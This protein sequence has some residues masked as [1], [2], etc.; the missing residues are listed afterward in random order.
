MDKTCIPAVNGLNTE[1]PGRITEA[2]LSRL[3]LNKSTGG[4]CGLS[5]F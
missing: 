1:T 2:E 4:F 5:G 3:A